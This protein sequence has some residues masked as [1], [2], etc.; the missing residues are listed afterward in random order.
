MLYDE[1]MYGKP[2]PRPTSN[3]F[4]RLTSNIS[5]DTAAW[6]AAYP[7]L[8][9][10]NTTMSGD[11]SPGA[12]VTGLDF[13][14]AVSLMLLKGGADLQLLCLEL[15][16]LGSD[17]SNL[18]RGLLT[19]AVWA[20]DA[21]TREGSRLVIQDCTIVL[22]QDEF[23]WQ[24]YYMAQVLGN[25]A[26]GSDV[27]SIV[28]T[29]LGSM[30]SSE[31]RWTHVSTPHT[32]WLNCRITGVPRVF[33]ITI[34]N[35]FIMSYLGLSMYITALRAVRTCS[36]LLDAVQTADVARPA[37]V[38]AA[39]VSLASCWPAEGVSLGP[40]APR[41]TAPPTLFIMGLPD[42]T[43]TLDLAGKSD[44]FILDPSVTVSLR[45]LTLLGM[46]THEAHS[47]N[48]EDA[49]DTAIALATGLGWAF[50]F[51]RRGQ[52]VLLEVVTVVLPHVELQQYGSIIA[53]ESAAV[54]PYFKQLQFYIQSSSDASMQLLAKAGAAPSS[55]QL[56]Q[57]GEL[58]ISFRAL[59]LPGLRGSQVNLTSMPGY[60]PGWSAAMYAAPPGN[61][62][63]TESGGGGSSAGGGG[64]SGWSSWQIGVLAAG[65]VTAGACL[66]AGFVY[67][68]RLRMRRDG[69]S[70]GGRRSGSHWGASKR[71]GGDVEA[72]G[73]GAGGGGGGLGDGGSGVGAD[74][75]RGVLERRPLYDSFDDPAF[76]LDLLKGGKPSPEDV[77][78][79][80][81]RVNAEAAEFNI[82]MT[83]ICG[84]GSYGVVYGGRWH[85]LTVAIKCM[86]FT[87]SA[88]H[89]LA[90][91][92]ARQQCIKEAAFCCTMHH[93]NVVATHHFY[94]KSTQRTCMFDEVLQAC[95]STSSSE[96]DANSLYGKPN[97][98]M[99]LTRA[100]KAAMASAGG[101]GNNN[102]DNNKEAG[103]KEISSRDDKEKEK[104]GSKKLFASDKEGSKKL[105]ASDKDSK[106]LQASDKDGSR[107]LHASPCRASGGGPAAPAAATA[108]AAAPAV[109]AAA[110]EA[111]QGPTISVS[112]AATAGDE[113]QAP[114]TAGDASVAGPSTEAPAPS[115]G[116]G[117]PTAPLTPPVPAAQP[118]P[119]PPAGPRVLKFAGGDLPPVKKKKRDR[120]FYTKLDVTDWRLYLVQ[121]YCD[122]GTLRQAVDEGRL[123]RHGGEERG[124]AMEAAAASAEEAARDADAA[125]KASAGA[126]ET[127]PEGQPGAEQDTASAA[128]RTYVIETGGFKPAA[129]PAHLEDFVYD[130]EADESDSFVVDFA[131]QLAAARAA[132]AAV[133]PSGGRAHPP[134]AALRS[135]VTAE[136]TNLLATATT[137]LTDADPDGESNIFGTTEDTILTVA[138]P[139]LAAA[140]GGGA[141]SA[142]A[143][144]EPTA[145]V[146]SGENA[147]NTSEA[148]NGTSAPLPVVVPPVGFPAPVA[149]AA[150]AAGAQEAAIAAAGA[151][152]AAAAG[153]INA[154]ALPS[155]L[156]MVVNTALGVASGVAY[157]HSRSI[158]HGD[159]SANNVLLQTT[160]LPQMP[161]VAKV[162]DFGLSRRLE[163]GQ[164]QLKNVR[165]GTPYYQAPEVAEKGTSTLAADVYS[166]GVLLWELYHGPPPWRRSRKQ[167]L[168]NNP[169]P[170]PP[171]PPPADSHTPSDAVLA[172]LRA[173]AAAARLPGGSV[174]TARAAALAA[175]EAGGWDDPNYLL[176]AFDVLSIAPHCP[177]RF[178]RLIRACM[179]PDPADRPTARAVVKALLRIERNM[180]AAAANAAA[181]ASASR[182]VSA[183]SMMSGPP[184]GAVMALNRPQPRSTT[185]G[186]LDAALLLEDYDAA[187][188]AVAAAVRTVTERPAAAG[189]SASAGAAAKALAEGD[190]DA[191]IAV[192]LEPRL[193]KKATNGLGS[194]PGGG[195]GSSRFKPPLL[196]AAGSTATISSSTLAGAAAALS[197]AAMT[198]PVERQSSGVPGA[199]AGGG[200]SPQAVS[201]AAAGAEAPA[202]AEADGSAAAAAA[203]A[204]AIRR[205]KEEMVATLE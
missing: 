5:L 205:S 69:S 130:K 135:M 202:A 10:P 106:R 81:A 155:D 67:A 51:P 32:L 188:Q 39:N 55:P 149:A 131:G 198:V 41:G 8:T 36:E 9:R 77:S 125:G 71:R 163:Q 115:G 29:F 126:L 30:T 88:P 134:R 26:T 181:A 118:P 15:V 62:N 73:D 25:T 100:L 19:G 195:A 183:S 133:P 136:S 180:A 165:H 80:L 50:H 97:R 137:N 66:T 35:S 156:H 86:V 64:S 111:A 107:R 95:Q 119:P 57:P 124:R 150:A 40:A 142:T 16:N 184:M 164:S 65:L 113:A 75:E 68:Q 61:D 138:P 161:V 14:G 194:G 110:A 87:N 22:T 123:F 146:T 89:L 31:L 176:H 169:K 197:S 128:L 159:L 79:I 174:E 172:G 144:A 2:L 175:H 204:A 170:P 17:T 27:T 23:R 203:Q 148:I 101:A 37:V 20:V 139:M 4:I 122:G 78:E 58:L 140:A 42:R 82:E 116:D 83:E 145:V 102:N 49:A 53:R 18:P 33:P 112:A 143:A 129:G 201:L 11:C 200:R 171:P 109:A 90:A 13:G 85:G 160:R 44:A 28:P 103:N 153:G 84:S 154:S 141:L 185:G 152:A 99:N 60:Y 199:A 120:I 147:L 105:H 104:E 168:E 24:S 94:L 108:S 56:A 196:G 47:V 46:G 117:A 178:G 132:A 121:E 3:L 48:V 189:G 157:L 45:Y 7:V 76:E 193:F 34:P 177:E 158:L 96:D 92:A 1:R 38:L 43:T 190:N 21:D 6:A 72:G 98:R 91:E 173:A 167:R 179:H 59:L 182:L 52:Q 162:S 127:V 151:V 192:G 70:G 63:Q 191:L 93:P 114:Q 187:A 54:L 186:P 12:D 74:G 166:L